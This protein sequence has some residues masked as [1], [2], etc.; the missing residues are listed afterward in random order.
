MTGTIQPVVRRVASSSSTMKMQPRMLSSW[1][2]DVARSVKSSPPSIAYI[3]IAA[4]ARPAT[5]SHQRMPSR[6]RFA[7]GNIRNDSNSTK[8]TWA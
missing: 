7:T 5:T 4:P 2:G 8:A 3:R 6:N 1:V